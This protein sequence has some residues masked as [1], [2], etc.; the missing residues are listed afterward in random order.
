[1]GLY[2]LAVTTPVMPTGDYVS[3]FKVI[4][5]VIV[6]IAWARL[7]TWVDKDT[8]ANHMA[9]DKINSGLLGG[10][11]I[12]FGAFLA[13]P[14]FWG[15]FPALLAVAGAELMIYLQVRKAKVGSNDDVREEFRTWVKNLGGTPKA[16]EEIT[17]AVQLVGAD[18]KLLP[19]PK[20]M[21]PEAEAYDGL[22]RMLTDPLSQR[23]RPDRHRT[24]RGRGRRSSTRSTGSTTTARRCPRPWRPTRWCT[25][26]RRPGWT[27]ARSASRRR[28]RSS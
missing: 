16:V 12:G 20:K 22:Q 13:I 15:A 9:R 21:T 11:I 3:G 17:G 8:L 26:R 5:V 19:A 6:L 14:T 18:G 2:M 28:G 24:D 7:L 23:G 4:P 25:S 10:L 1:M 27:S